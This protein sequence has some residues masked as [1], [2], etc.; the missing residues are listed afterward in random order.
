MNF[1]KKW[2]ELWP[3]ALSGVIS[4]AHLAS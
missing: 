1:E 4:Y 2:E 3:N